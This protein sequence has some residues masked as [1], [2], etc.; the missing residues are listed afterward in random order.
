MADQPPEVLFVTPERRP[1]SE[2]AFKSATGT[3]ATKF[4]RL[5]P[6]PAPLLPAVTFSYDHRLGSDDQLLEKL[7]WHETKLTELRTYLNENSKISKQAIA[8]IFEWEEHEQPQVSES[9]KLIK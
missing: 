6:S 7:A 9:R 1:H 2:M 5:E 8:S 3:T 4:H